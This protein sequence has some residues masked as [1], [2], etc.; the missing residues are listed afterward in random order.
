[1]TLIPSLPP[2]LLPLKK[3]TTLLTGKAGK[4]PGAAISKPL[5]FKDCYHSFPLAEV[6]KSSAV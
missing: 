6:S 2:R 4:D 3:K 1:M 5:L